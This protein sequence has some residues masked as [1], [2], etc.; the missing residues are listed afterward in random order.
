LAE[1]NHHILVLEEKK[2]YQNFFLSIVWAGETFWYS[3]RT[4]TLM[5][6][7]WK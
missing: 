5:S 7:N 6:Y 3:N 4:P 2:I 1:K